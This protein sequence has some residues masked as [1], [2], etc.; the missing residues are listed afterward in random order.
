MAADLPSKSAPVAYL[1]PPPVFTWTGFYLGLNAGY[2]WNNRDVTTAGVFAGNIANV[3]AARRPGSINLDSNGFVGGGQA[4]FNYQTGMF[5]VGVEADLMY[6]DVKGR[7]SYLSAAGDL[8]DFRYELD[9]LGTVRGRLGVAFDRVLV[10]GTGGLAWGKAHYNADFYSNAA[11]QPL[12]FQGGQSHTRTGYA[13]G[14]G[15]E[16]A[17]PMGGTSAVT[18]RGEYLYADLG[19]RLVNVSAVPPA[20]AGAYTTGFQNRMHLLRAG[21]NYKF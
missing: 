5:V 3:A 4:G 18:L 10:Y 11:G 21:V 19:K 20:G 16:Y 14:A 1:P 17:I 6:S 12:A 2:G 7:A 9:Y 8:S 15:V 13:V